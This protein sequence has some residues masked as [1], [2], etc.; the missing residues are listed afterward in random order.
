LS[1]NRSN[2]KSTST[3]Q[4]PEWSNSRTWAHITLVVQWN[5]EGFQTNQHTSQDRSDS[6]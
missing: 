5:H 2:Y 1:R 6:T 3:K 4:S